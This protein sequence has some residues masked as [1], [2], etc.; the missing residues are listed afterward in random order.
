M[1]VFRTIRMAVSGVWGH[2]GRAGRFRGTPP[3]KWPFPGE[4]AAAQSLTLESATDSNV[5]DWAAARNGA[6]FRSTYFDPHT[7]D[8]IIATFAPST[9]YAQ[10]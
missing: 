8:M 7:S 5:S 10:H 2:W 3:P 4:R 1:A 6:R 9:L